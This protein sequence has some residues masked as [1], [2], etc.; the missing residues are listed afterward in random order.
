MKL[1]LH[2]VNTNKYDIYEVDLQSVT[3]GQAEDLLDAIDVDNMEFKSNEELEKCIIATLKEKIPK[4]QPV[5]TSIF[6]IPDEKFIF[7]QIDELVNVITSIASY[8]LNELLQCASNSDTKK[9]SSSASLYQILFDL[10]ITICDKFKGLNPFIL[11]HETMQEVFLLIKRLNNTQ[12]QEND[13]IQSCNGD[14]IRR[15]ATDDS[16]F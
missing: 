1:R 6:D 10:Q 4:I 13:H 11:R 14:V 15:P 9:G 2:I 12:T 8:A 5:I 7:V 3:F 16:W